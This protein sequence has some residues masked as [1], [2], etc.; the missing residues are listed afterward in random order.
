MRKSHH[1]S[2]GS[3]MLARLDVCTTLYVGIKLLTVVM[4]VNQIV[5]I[6]IAPMHVCDDGIHP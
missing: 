1:A 6:A 2:I 3:G 5:L 4:H